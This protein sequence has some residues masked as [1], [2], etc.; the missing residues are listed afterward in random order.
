MTESSA[1]VVGEN[2]PEQV[3]FK[4]MTVIGA[5][6][7]YGFIGVQPRPPAEWILKTYAACLQV[8]R[9]PGSADDAISLLASTK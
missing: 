6:Q 5:N 8:V 9:S 1:F 2:T 7:G 4:L 3:A